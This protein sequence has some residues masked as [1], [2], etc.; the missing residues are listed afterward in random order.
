MAYVFAQKNKRMGVRRAIGAHHCVLLCAPDDT[1]VDTT[2][3]E[4]V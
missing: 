3:S 2:L 4:L 1:A